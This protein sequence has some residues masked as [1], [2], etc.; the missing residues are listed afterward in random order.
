MEWLN[1]HHL[2]YFWTVARTGG[3][4]AASAELR[5]A[6]PTISGQLRMLEDHFGE[7]LFHRVGRRLELT[8]VGRLVYRYA[9]EIF[10]LGR[11]L[12]DA[13]RGR[14]TGRPLRIAVG[15]DDQ[16]PK[17]IAYRLME[18]ALKMS[19]PVRLVCHEDK[20]ERL[21]ADLAVHALDLVLTDAPLSPSVKVRA[22]SHLLGECG[23]TVFAAKSLVNR[24]RRNFPRSLDGA[25]FLMPSD[26]TVLRRSLDQWFAQHDVRPAV[27]GEFDDSALLSAFGERG[28]GVFA[29]PAAIESE[30]RRQYDVRAI[31]RIDQV[32]QRFYAI[33]VERRLKHPAVVAISEAAK[34]KLFG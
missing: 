21:L 27:L 17:L 32:R 2:L 12:T 22:F 7:K 6:Q 30:I 13:V 31:G 19:D 16:V 26:N 8:E 25:P 11:E 34:E 15:V 10:T 18:P 14:P 29:A 5:L 28:V 33:S 3:V 1:Y 24:Y 4:S 23:T 9:D 20:T